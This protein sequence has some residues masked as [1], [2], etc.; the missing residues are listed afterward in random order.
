MARIK[1]AVKKNFWKTLTPVQRHRIFM[2]GDIEPWASRLAW[3]IYRV[4]KGVEER[5]NPNLVIQG[6]EFV[7]KSSKAM[8]SSSAGFDERRL[9]AWRRKLPA[10][11]KWS[12]LPIKVFAETKNKSLEREV[13]NLMRAAEELLGASYESKSGAYLRSL[14][15]AIERVHGDWAERGSLGG[16][17]DEHRF[18]LNV[19]LHK[20]T[21]PPNAKLTNEPNALTFSQIRDAFDNVFPNN[22][23]DDKT[24]RDMVVK[25]MGFRCLPEKRGPKGP[26]IKH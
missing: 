12:R 13:Q 16:F 14:A 2:Y 1:N 23:I 10:L 5:M 3:Q 17:V 18:W 20:E 7:A 22:T 26:R 6:F 15:N 25:E 8:N 11:L 21:P 9:K 4:T 24:L 19:F